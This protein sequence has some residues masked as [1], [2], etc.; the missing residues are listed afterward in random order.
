MANRYWPG[1]DRIGKRLRGGLA[2]T[3]TPW[4]TVV[5]EV[6]DVKLGSRDAE[7]MPQVYQPATQTVASEGVL[8]S[9]GEFSATNGWI[10]LRSRMAPE[11]MEDPLRAR[12]RQVDQQ[13]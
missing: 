10:V 8:A 2:E 3:A 13:F 4:M 7:T 12:V 9:P 11:Q 6:D 5:G 1:Q